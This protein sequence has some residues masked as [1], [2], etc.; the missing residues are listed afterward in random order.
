MSSDTTL[1]HTGAQVVVELVG[2]PG[3]G[4]TT[5]AGELL[6][7]CRAR[8]LRAMSIV[9]AARP[10]AART[11]PGRLVAAVAPERLR[12]PL[13]WQVFYAASLFAA[14]GAALGRSR[15]IRD[16]VRS[17]RARSIPATS[18]RHTLFWFAQLVG[19]RRFLAR[20][21]EPGEVLVVDDGFLHRV[22]ALHASP[23]GAPD[24]EAVARYVATIPV[25]DLV[26]AVHARPQT[27]VRRIG[28]RGLWRHRAGMT[29]DDL[30]RYVAHAD[31]VVRAA[32]AAA[33][34]RGWRIVD[35]DNDEDDVQAL[36]AQL[37]VIVGEGAR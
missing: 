7:L 36:R 19:R 35:V 15:L 9:E 32:V 13:L 30:V 17:E 10:H 18:K 25:P 16:A 12:G 14:L 21:P 34:E 22:V 1:R 26:V 11:L 20:R 31:A 28:E 27:C 4:K 37:P 29:E 2:T 6:A 5:A 33:R 23:D 24:L 3:A 8:G